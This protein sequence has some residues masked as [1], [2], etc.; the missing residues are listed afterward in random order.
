MKITYY[1]KKLV[2]K[3]GKEINF[4]LGKLQLRIASHQFSLWNNCNPLF[5]FLF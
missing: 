2:Y 5:N 4:H 1:T 3:G